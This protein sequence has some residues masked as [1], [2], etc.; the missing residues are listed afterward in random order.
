[1]KV[2][3][4]AAFSS[5]DGA[6]AFD[7]RTFLMCRNKTERKVS[8]LLSLSCGFWS[9]CSV[10]KTVLMGNTWVSSHSPKTCVRG[11]LKTLNLP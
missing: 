11:E 4:S 3:T 7:I 9:F 2:F 6:A 8:I 10:F 5:S 1:M